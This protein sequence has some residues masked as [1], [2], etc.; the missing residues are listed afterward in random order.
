[1]VN[2]IIGRTNRFSAAISERSISNWVSM[3]LLSD[4]GYYFVPSELKLD[5]WEEPQKIWDISPLKYANNIKTPTLFIHADE[6]YRCPL[7]EGLQMY[8]ALKMHKVP[9]KLCL[10]H[11]ENHQ[12][13]RTGKPCNRAQRIKVMCEWLSEHFG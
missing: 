8:M 10:F 9:A 1:L 6:D 4:I 7:S 2:L 11:G 5:M 12:L 3:Q 13:S